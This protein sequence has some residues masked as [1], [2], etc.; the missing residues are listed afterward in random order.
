Y[1]QFSEWKDICI[2]LY[3]M[4]QCSDNIRFFVEGVASEIS[5]ANDASTNMIN[6]YEAGPSHSNFP[7]RAHQQWEEL[8][9]MVKRLLS[10][11]GELSNLIVLLKR[12][13][14]EPLRQS[15]ETDNCPMNSNHAQGE[16]PSFSPA[17]AVQIEIAA[18]RKKFPNF[19]L[20][21]LGSK[22]HSPFNPKLWSC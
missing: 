12:L 19:F 2:L 20:A 7:G 1:D 14:V 5:R 11:E 18:F 10:Y 13:S 9:Q 22:E 6:L 8:C 21:A 17:R 16:S 4:E 15:F 3:R